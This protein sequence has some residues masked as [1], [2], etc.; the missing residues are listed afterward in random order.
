MHSGYTGKY[1]KVV[2]GCGPTSTVETSRGYKPVEMKKITTHVVEDHCEPH[3]QHHGHH[4][5]SSGS[6]FSL[7]GE[8]SCCMIIVVVLVV[9][10]ILWFVI[11]AWK[12][13]F[14]QKRDAQNVV[15]GEIDNGRLFLATAIATLIVVLGL[16]LL[17]C[18]CKRSC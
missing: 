1:S 14:V 6:C 13:D 4:M 2:A 7:C 9:F 16:W 5:K 18:L 11:R 8:W 15:T 12:P 17:C 10:L 3:V